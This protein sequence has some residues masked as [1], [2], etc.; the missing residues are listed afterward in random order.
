MFIISGLSRMTA[1]TQSDGDN[2]LF[3]NVITRFYKDRFRLLL[4]IYF[5]SEETSDNDYPHLLYGEIK[6]QAIDFFLRNPDYLAFELLNIASKEATKSSE[7]KKIV[8]KIY[9]SSEPEIRR[10]EMEKF[11][12][13]AYEDIDDII[14]FLCSTG[15]LK[16]ES[17]MR[18][19]M[20]V[21]EKH[22]YVTKYG[23]E[24]LKYAEAN[25]QVAKWYFDRCGIIKDYLGGTTG[26]ELK[27][28]QYQVEEYSNTTYKDKIQKIDDLVIEK[29]QE[30]YNEA[31]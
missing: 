4:V 22:Y 16:Y 6:I 26:S 11:F 17:K 20:R 30:L 18:T 31:L 1:I 9:H 3:E 15:L 28:R 21:A 24:K 10:V 27:A 8:K 19:D 25:I 29:F 7:I 13:G 23:V 12:Y 14:A 5:F 2:S